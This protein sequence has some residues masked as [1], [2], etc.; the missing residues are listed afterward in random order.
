MRIILFI[1]IITLVSCETK[2]NNTYEA[3]ERVR[4]AKNNGSDIIVSTED[5][6]TTT[7]TIKKPLTEWQSYKEET[8]N[9]INTADD[10]IKEIKK[11]KVKAAYH[12]KFIKQV[13]KLEKKNNDL[14]TQMSDY[15][16]DREAKW[17]I[18]KLD[19]EHQSDDIK[20][21]MKFLK[22]SDGAQDSYLQE[23]FK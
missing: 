7:I 19:M 9:K 4:E 12:D 14:K 10:H 2:E 6:V 13:E 3:F 23:L 16:K 8:L 22:Q 18:F 1:A 11:R 17:K 20:S 21:E 15:Y 5:S